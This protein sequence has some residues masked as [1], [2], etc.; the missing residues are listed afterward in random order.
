M[1]QKAL[2]PRGPLLPG[3]PG[4]KELPLA[5]MSTSAAAIIC[6]AKSALQI[7]FQDE[8]PSLSLR[9]SGFASGETA[10]TT[11][12]PTPDNTRTLSAIVRDLSTFRPGNVHP[13]SGSHL[14]TS[15]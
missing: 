5:P 9:L 12:G 6:R 2:R 8:T 14:L 4:S 15:S 3:T 11:S 13:L 7:I 1:I 10:R